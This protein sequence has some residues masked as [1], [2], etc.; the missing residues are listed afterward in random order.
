MKIAIDARWIFPHISGIG[1]V[2]EKLIRYLG[3]IDPGNHYLLLFDRPELR[4]KYGRQWE[5]APNLETA[6]V[7][8]RLFSPAGQW[9]LP[10]WL[11]GRGIDLFHSP[12]YLYPLLMKSPP[13][14]VTI[15]DLIPLKFPEFTPRAKKTRFNFVFRWVLRRSV[16]RAARVIAVSRHTRADL[17]GLLGLE[18]EKIRVVYNGVDRSYRK[19]PEGEV[20]SRLYESFKISSPYFFFVG[21]F[22]P[23]KNVTGLIR[24]FA[25]FIGSTDGSP[26]LVIAGSP[27]PRYPEA[28]K[29]VESLG[30]ADR[31]RFLEKVDEEELLYLYN[32][33]LVLVLPSLYEGFGL[34]PL[35]AMACGTPVICSNRGSLPE[36]VGD[37]ALLVEPEVEEIAA[38]M[39][40]IWEDEEL[41][42]ELSRR[43]L[44]RAAS[45]SWEKTAAETLAVYNEVGS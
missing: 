33:A 1:R 15:H 7:P 13:V 34:P 12:N 16:R 21:R 4:A 44:R 28:G 41:R 25:D 18:E 3:K 36:V 37:A 11:R 27:D 10:S 29:M 17:I 6:L 22:D 2:T 38:G 8:W 14:V 43:G 5:E 20:K 30:I 23:Y 26:Q 35:E 19:L 32:G 40:K 31:V 24:A 42:T 39:T 45:F 9:G